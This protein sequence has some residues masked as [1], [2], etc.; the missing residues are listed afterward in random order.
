MISTADF[1]DVLRRFRL[2]EPAQLEE[3]S[4]GGTGQGEEP[5]VLASSLIERGWLTPYQANLLL[6][7]R[8][9][10]LLLGSYVLLERIGE[11]G[12]GAVFKARNWKLGQ[13]VALKLMHKDRVANAEAVK[14]FQREVRAA[15]QLDHPNIVHALDAD[16]VNGTHLLV[17]EFVAGADLSHIVKTQGPLPVAQACEC[18]RQAALG[19]Q[20]AL[21]RG[22]VHRDIKPSNLFVT[23]DG[24]RVKILDFGLARQGETEGERSSTTLTREGTVMGS[25]DYIAPEQALDSHQVDC[26]A[27]LYSL[28]CTFY[29]LLTGQVPFPGG[30]ALAKLLKHRTEEPKPLRQLRPE[31]P[32]AVS[33][34]VRKLMAKEP[35][36]RYQ[37]PTELVVTLQAVMRGEPVVAIPTAVP[38]ATSDR[39]LLMRPADPFAGLD[40]GDATPTPSATAS[41]SPIAPVRSRHRPRILAGSIAGLLLVG[42]LAIGLPSLFSSRPATQLAAGTTPSPPSRPTRQDSP[43]SGRTG[44]KTETVDWKGAINS[45]DNLLGQAKV[46]NLIGETKIAYP[47]SRCTFDV[48]TNGF[49]LTLDSGNGNPFAYMGSISGTGNVEFFM[50]PSYTGFKDA[51]MVL[52]GDKPNTTSGKFYVKK[53][54]VQLEKPRGVTAISGD[55]IVGG[56]GFNDCLRWRHSEQLKD[57]VNITLLDAGNAGAAYLDLNGC[58]ETA[59]SLTMTARNKI[60]T[61]AAEGSGS[62]AL[63][64]KALTLEGRR[65]PAGEYTAATE[66]WIEGQG[67]VIVRP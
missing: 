49:T 63:I 59:A 29:Y 41:A 38:I 32:E 14:R 21:E 60:K 34:V 13:V 17:M 66:P 37:T 65:K 7:G 27:D 24:T 42:G 20:H 47:V 48:V 23:Q 43:T 40:Y 18:I 6:R 57:S 44:R 39:T 67:K 52:G 53:G 5:R 28:G 9:Q 4:R 51:P 50:G 36:Q 25:V 58:S 16:E 30:E 62:G 35:A 56:Q 10:E 2:L 8:G 26:R 19:L 3:L 46:L 33:G 31:V 45:L 11:G 54:R 12:M 64:V 61:D 1:F 15:A 22:L 55:I